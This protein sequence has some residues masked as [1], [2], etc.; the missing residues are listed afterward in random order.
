MDLH[1]ALA[2][3]KA[4]REYKR[5][6]VPL[7][8]VEK[9]CY[10]ASR[11]PT[12][13]NA[14]YRHVIAIDDPRIIKSIQLVSPS[15]LANPPLLLVIITDLREAI[16]KTGPLA[17]RS[18]YVDSGAAGENILLAATELGLGS[19]F[20]MIPSMA[21]I[22]EIL[23]LPE[24]YR[25]DLIIP[26]GFPDQSKKKKSTKARVGANSVFH[27]QFGVPLVFGQQQQETE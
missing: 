13:C 25:V 16:E 7:E 24:H 12:A 11:A 17:E 19:Q 23:K 18:S 5:D 20:T 6:P 15:L 22:R 8:V 4:T 10:A 2:K 26:I 1:Q 14:P 9:L 3:R 21:G 27:N